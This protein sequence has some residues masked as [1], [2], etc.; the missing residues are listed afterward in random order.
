[1]RDV[2]AGLLLRERLGQGER[3][4]EQGERLEEQG[5]RLEGQ[6]ER[7]EVVERQAA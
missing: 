2:G 4:E 7:L 1:M 5:E 3:L 6:G